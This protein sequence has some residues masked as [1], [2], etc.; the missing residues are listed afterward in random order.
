MQ[1]K[2]KKSHFFLIKVSK[3]FT[4]P[5]FLENLLTSPFIYIKLVYNQLL[6]Y[7]KFF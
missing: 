4:K 5:I 1:L 3:K 6:Q 7:K 2:K